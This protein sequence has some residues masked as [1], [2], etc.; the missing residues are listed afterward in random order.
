M[1]LTMHAP[2]MQSDNNIL[3]I[4]PSRNL[5]SLNNCKLFLSRMR[6]LS[7]TGRIGVYAVSDEQLQPM[8]FNPPA[9]LCSLFSGDKANAF[10]FF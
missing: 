1:G 3:F 6:R 7:K 5:N 10:D 8:S 9:Q 2:Q 4:A